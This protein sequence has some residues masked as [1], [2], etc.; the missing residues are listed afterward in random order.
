MAFR[1]GQLPAFVS[2]GVYMIMRTI[3]L[4]ALLTFGRWPDHYSIRIVTSIEKLCPV[5]RAFCDERADGKGLPKIP[6]LAYETWETTN[7]KR[8]GRWP[9]HY[10]IRIVTSIEKLC[11]VHRALCDER[12]DGKGLPKNP[13]LAYETWETTNS[14]RQVARSLFHKNC[15]K[16]R[17]TVPRSSRFLR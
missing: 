3:L 9:D 5:H 14:K 12:A 1:P 16:H 4:C 6:D 15:Y 8:E 17:E 2:S 11:P 13:D 10:S 7:S